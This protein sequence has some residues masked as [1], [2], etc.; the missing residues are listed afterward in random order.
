[1]NCLVCKS[2]MKEFIKQSFSCTKTV[3]DLTHSINQGTP[4]KAFN[5]LKYN[6]DLI[7]CVIVSSF[8][9][10]M[11]KEIDNDFIMKYFKPEMDDIFIDLVSSV[12]ATEL[13][14]K[15]YK[16]YKEQIFQK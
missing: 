7:N 13:K 11:I 9:S 16:L 5:V 15:I 14:S 1:M 6:S 3:H 2:E 8:S 12:D 4:E 10:L